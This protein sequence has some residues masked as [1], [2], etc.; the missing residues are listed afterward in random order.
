MGEPKPED[1]Y[2]GQIRI[3]ADYETY[4]DFFEI[5]D[6]NF[7]SYEHALME[8]MRIY[9]EERGAGISGW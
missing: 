4:R 9:E 1:E 7:I 8:L 5:A 6:D 3:R 2:S